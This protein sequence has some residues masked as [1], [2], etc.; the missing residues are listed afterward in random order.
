MKLHGFSDMVA[1]LLITGISITLIFTT[2]SDQ[3]N[4]INDVVDIIKL[5]I[6]DINANIDTRNNIQTLTI[7]GNV[8]SFSDFRYESIIISDLTI[9]DLR[10][11]QHSNY[12]D[13]G[14]KWY[15]GAVQI[16]GY[17][18]NG[19]ICGER[20][21]LT[22]LYMSNPIYTTYLNSGSSS[23]QPFNTQRQ[24]GITSG[25][26]CSGV[27][28]PSNVLFPNDKT[29]IKLIGLS[30]YGPANNKVHIESGETKSF[31]IIITGHNIDTNSID[32][33]ESIKSDPK[34]YLELTG[35][36]YITEMVSNAVEV[37]VRY[38]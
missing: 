1:I 16:V 36:N 24:S 37:Y 19:N 25:V 28:T 17:N 27:Q 7:V 34:L 29:T 10:I 32:L 33:V 3:R 9:G 15:D 14:P 31:K 38:R 6:V 22:P 4:T 26:G 18:T 5:D 23:L 13:T 30:N 35:T 11:V 21:W 8:K 2:A 12:T 20:T